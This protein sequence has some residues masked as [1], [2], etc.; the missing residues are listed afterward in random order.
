MSHGICLL[1]LSF[2]LVLVSIWLYPRLQNTRTQACIICIFD[3]ILLSII[4]YGQVSA[5]SCCETNFK[6]PF[7]MVAMIN[8]DKLMSRFRL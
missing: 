8:L 2:K 7:I 1:Y 5:S 4:K 3:H 6:V